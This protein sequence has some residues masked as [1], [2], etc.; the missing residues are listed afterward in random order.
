MIDRQHFADVIDEI[1][2]TLRR[3][4][5]GGIRRLECSDDHL[6]ALKTWES[7]SRSAPSGAETLEGHP[8]GSR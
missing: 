4:A 6:N 2:H 3:M 8:G 5:E 1:A 7:R